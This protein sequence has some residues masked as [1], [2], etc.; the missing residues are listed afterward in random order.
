M[1]TFSR[2]QYLQL[3]NYS[4]G[5]LAIIFLIQT[6]LLRIYLQHNSSCVPSLE[7]C[8]IMEASRWLPRPLAGCFLFITFLLW[9]LPLKIIHPV[10]FLDLAHL[11]G[12]FF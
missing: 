2:K 1:I 4:A 11:T 10:G 8:F 7:G 5:L 3:M 12:S 9:L 6:D